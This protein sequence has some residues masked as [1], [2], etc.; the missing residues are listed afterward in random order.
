LGFAHGTARTCTGLLA[1]RWIGQIGTLTGKDSVRSSRRPLR[2]QRR[3]NMV[4]KPTGLVIGDEHDGVLPIG[5]AANSVNNL[6][7]EQLAALNVGWRM[8]IILIGTKKGRIDE[9]D[10]R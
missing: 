6:R 10:L 5:P 7:N 4:I 8:F 3:R 2:R 1:C 9:G